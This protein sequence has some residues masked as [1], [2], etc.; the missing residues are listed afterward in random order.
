MPPSAPKKKGFFSAGD[1][2]ILSRRTTDVYS[3]RTM[4]VLRAKGMIRE[5]ALA[6]FTVGELP[7]SWPWEACAI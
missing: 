2:E 3:V 1:D 5:R 6:E 7:R 4:E